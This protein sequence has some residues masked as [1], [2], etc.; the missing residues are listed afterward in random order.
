MTMLIIVLRESLV[1]SGSSSSSREAVLVLSQ[2]VNAPSC[3][4]CTWCPVSSQ[5]YCV[6]VSLW[7][8][9]HKKE[10]GYG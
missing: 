2:P 6:L 5:G 10:V 1:G 9:D 8:G 7:S 4:W 3:T